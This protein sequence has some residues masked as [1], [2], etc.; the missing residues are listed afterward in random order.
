MKMNQFKAPKKFG[1]LAFAV[2]ITAILTVATISV[3]NLNTKYKAARTSEK[4]TKNS[5]GKTNAVNHTRIQ[6]TG[7]YVHPP[8]NGVNVPFRKYTVTA[9]KGETISYK[10]SKIIIPANIFCDTKG[11]AIKGKVDIKYREFHNPVDFF[12]SGIPMTYDSGGI[13]YTFE[14]A[15]MLDISGEQNGVPVMIQPGKSLKVEMLSAQK[16]GKFNLYALDTITKKWV[17][18][19]ANNTNTVQTAVTASVKDTSDASKPIMPRKANPKNTSFTFNADKNDFPE[20]YALGNTI[21]EV[22]PKKKGFDSKYKDVD[23]ENVSITRIKFTDTYSMTISKGTETHSFTVY[24]VVD[25]KD[26][27]KATKD[28]NEQYA[29]YLASVNVQKTMETSSKAYAYFS[30]SHFGIWNSDCPECLPQ[31]ASLAAT[32]VENLNDNLQG[33]DVYLVEKG[34]NAMYIYHPGHN[35]QFDPNTVNFA[36]CITPKNKIAV[37]TNNDF[38]KINITTGVYTFIMKVI[39]KEISSDDD[40][41]NIFN[42]YL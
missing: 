40:V 26:Y 4:I 16:T 31:G 8:I 20:L 38:K 33:L 32:F 36:W 9:E 35:C 30:V 6:Q 3:W 42:T 39:D 34:K 37:F 23:W 17:F 1:G 22:D 21:F 19:S 13:Q 27:G 28:F 15:G 7:A 2:L 10:G 41:H 11:N 5:A 14:S 24:P 25:A 12:V 29:N 18:V